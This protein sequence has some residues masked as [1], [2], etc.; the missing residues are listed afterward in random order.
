MCGRKSGND[1]LN[2]LII[3]E[4]HPVVLCKTCES[5]INY[6][7]SL[8]V[9]TEEARSW[10]RQGLDILNNNKSHDKELYRFIINVKNSLK[11]VQEVEKLKQELDLKMM[12]LW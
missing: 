5:Y 4:D 7:E 3:N 9:D 1:E 11:T 12:E 6:F 10:I 2:L 8:E